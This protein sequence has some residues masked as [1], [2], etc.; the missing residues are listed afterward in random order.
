MQAVGR[1]YVRCVNEVMGRTGTLWEGRYKACLV[2]DDEYLL[3][4]Y[5]Y[6]ELNP[7][8]ACMVRRPGDHEWSSYHHNALGIADPLVQP[9]PTYLSLGL[10]QARRLEPS[11]RI[12]P[13]GV[14][15]G[16]LATA[17]PL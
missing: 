17:L 13:P 5:R 4:C 9:H 3:T 16:G 12:A 11:G 6:I 14:S 10:D 7:V 2:E 15:T 8:R 1:R